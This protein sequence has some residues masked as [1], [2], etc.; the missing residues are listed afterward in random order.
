MDGSV[1]EVKYYPIYYAGSQNADTA[2][3][4]DSANFMPVIK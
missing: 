2:L 4:T 1:G 3:T